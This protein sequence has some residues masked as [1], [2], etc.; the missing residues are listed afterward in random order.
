MR[1]W[2]LVTGYENGGKT[3]SV[4]HVECSGFPINLINGMAQGNEVAARGFGST[5]GRILPQFQ[6]IGPYKEPTLL[7]KTFN[8]PKFKLRFRVH[9]LV[10]AILALNARKRWR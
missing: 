10:Y 5:A 9:I 7:L 2:L 6:L 3:Q 4:R 1:S 8:R